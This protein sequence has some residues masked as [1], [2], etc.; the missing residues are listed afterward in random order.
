MGGDDLV[1]GKK[2]VTSDVPYELKQI[3]SGLKKA[4]GLEIQWNKNYE[5]GRKTPIYLKGKIKNLY[6]HLFSIELT[7]G[8]IVTFT[9]KDIYAK[10]IKLLSTKTGKNIIK[11]II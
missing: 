5:D 11:T 2:E 10:N 9:Y 1:R 7:N 3:K 6:S 4:I 8:R